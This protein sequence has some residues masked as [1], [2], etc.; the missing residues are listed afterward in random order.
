MDIKWD[1]FPTSLKI[2][3]VVPIFKKGNRKDVAN[4]RPIAI[5]SVFDKII[6]KAFFI[7]YYRGTKYPK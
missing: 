1:I 7:R 5:L 2:A 3:K 4:Y 6:T